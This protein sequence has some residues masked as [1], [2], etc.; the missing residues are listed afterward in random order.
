LLWGYDYLNF[1]F[2]GLQKIIDANTASASHPT[3]SYRSSV[4]QEAPAPVGPGAS[5]N[6]EDTSRIAS[7]AFIS[8]EFKDHP[9]KDESGFA[10]WLV[11][12]HPTISITGKCPIFWEDPYSALVDIHSFRY[13]SNKRLPL[14]SIYYLNKRDTSVPKLG[15]P[16]KITLD[17]LAFIHTPH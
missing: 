7:T 4:V 10:S 5:V 8:T 6:I 15:I 1:N 16:G 17:T 3:C 2:E 12:Q 11:R 9:N 13:G 14:I